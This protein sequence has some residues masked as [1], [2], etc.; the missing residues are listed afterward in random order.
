MGPCWAVGSCRIVD[1]EWL[2]R[3]VVQVWQVMDAPCEVL[4]AAR[5]LRFEYYRTTNPTCGRVYCITLVG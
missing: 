1:Y 2:Y 4:K 5:I 3:I